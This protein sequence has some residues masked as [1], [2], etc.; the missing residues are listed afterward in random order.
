MNQIKKCFRFQ[1]FYDIHLEF[2]N[3]FPKIPPLTNYLFLAGD[4]GKLS[5]SN[6][7]PFFDYCSDNW[8]KTFYVLGNHEYYSSNKTYDKLNEEYKEFFKNYSNVFLLDD[9]YYD[10]EDGSDS[11]RIYGSTLWSS[12]N[13]NQSLNDFNMIKMKNDKNWTVPIDLEYFNSLYNNSAKKLFDQIKT[14]NWE[15]NSE[16]KNLIIMTHFPPIRKT[17]DQPNLTSH[18]MYQ[19]Q[20][21]SIKKYF[22][23]DFTNGY[24]KVWDLTEKDLYSNVKLWISGHTHYSYDF[25]YRTRFIGNQLGYKSEFEHTGINLEGTYEI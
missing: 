15:G 13:S 5:G 17:D 7:K 11:Y 12:I 25:N 3:S 10:L 14:T 8:K 2:F 18:P 16:P 9:S 6:F 23:N 1:I 20:D 21:E 24:L 19:N 22:A 4:I